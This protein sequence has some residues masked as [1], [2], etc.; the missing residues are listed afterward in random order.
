MMAPWNSGSIGASA[1]PPA[2]GAALNSRRR[3]GY[4]DSANLPRYSKEPNTLL[5]K[6]IVY[7]GDITKLDVDVIVNAANHSLLGGGGVD[8]AIHRKAGPQLRAFNQTLGGCK[9]SEVKASPGFNLFCKQI[10][11][12]VGP[13]G[14]QP[15]ALRSCYI[16]ALELLKVVVEC[17][18]KWLKVPSNFE[19]I[20]YI[21][22]CV[23]DKQDYTLYDQLLSKIKARAPVS[24]SSV[25]APPV[26]PGADGDGITTTSTGGEDAG[27]KP[28]L[29]TASQDPPH[30]GPTG[31]D[32]MIVDE[33][34]DEQ[35][36]DNTP[37]LQQQI[38]GAKESE[39]KK[40]ECLQK[41][42]RKDDSREGR[43][44]WGGSWV[45]CGGGEDATRE[46][47]DGKGD[48]NDR[49]RVFEY[50][51][52]KKEGMELMPLKAGDA[53]GEQEG[54]SGHH[55]SG[56]SS[57]S[58]TSESD[59]E[60][61]TEEEEQQ[62]GEED[63]E[64]D[65]KGW[66]VSGQ[67][68]EGHRPKPH[69][70]R[71]AG[72]LFSREYLHGGAAVGITGFISE[73]SGKKMR[74]NSARK[75]RASVDDIGGGNDS[76]DTLSEGYLSEQEQI[77]ERL[78][79]RK[80][81][82]SD[83]RCRTHAKRKDKRPKKVKISKKE[84]VESLMNEENA[85]EKFLEYSE[86]RG[87]SM[88][89]SNTLSSGATPRLT[90]RKRRELFRK[91]RVQTA[92]KE[93]ES[94]GQKEEEEDRNASVSTSS[95]PS[96]SQEFHDTMS[97][98]QVKAND[99]RSL[100]S[101][102]SLQSMKE[103]GKTHQNKKNDTESKKTNGGI[104]GSNNKAR[105]DATK[106]NTISTP[107]EGAGNN[108]SNKKSHQGQI[109]HNG[110]PRS[111]SSSTTPRGKTR[112]DKKQKTSKFQK[113][114][115]AR[116]AGSFE[117]CSSAT[118]GD[119]ATSSLLGEPSPRKKPSS[120]SS[121]FEDLKPSLRLPLEKVTK[122]KP[123]KASQSSSASSSQTVVRG[124][125]AGETTKKGNGD[126]QKKSKE[127]Q[128]ARG[129]RQGSGKNDASGAK[130]TKGH[131]Q[132][133]N[134][135]PSSDGTSEEIGDVMEKKQ[136]ST[137]RGGEKR[138]GT[139]AAEQTQLLENGKTS[140]KTVVSVATPRG[141]KCKGKNKDKKGTQQRGQDVEAATVGRIELP[142]VDPLQSD[143]LQPRMDEPPK[144]TAEPGESAKPK[145][146]SA[147]VAVSERLKNLQVKFSCLEKDQDSMSLSALTKSGNR[148][149]NDDTPRKGAS[150]SNRSGSSSSLS[151]F[152]SLPE[153]GEA[154]RG[155]EAP[156][157][158]K[159]GNSKPTKKGTKKPR[160]VQTPGK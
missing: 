46:E 142:P 74:K 30:H 8:G 50:R 139:P 52:D 15:Q 106:D 39:D 143:A 155:K 43:D 147:Q 85:F 80:D 72:E 58:R 158:R 112:H 88:S 19:A 6:V 130:T 119:S 76:S 105:S 7:K 113:L 94:E 152:H 134:A 98:T 91:Q 40:P 32:R 36:K 22:F 99:P 17:V 10:F 47:E 103:N 1:V 104:T 125:Q 41:K 135:I 133:R 14:E 138:E 56:S 5:R 83:R 44:D 110:G 96:T 25:F 82:L 108:E 115:A 154:S 73:R 124:E 157:P 37:S 3:S 90:P 114:A 140:S 29:G 151:S 117:K 31:R 150:G 53:S 61:A 69:I 148:A 79:D 64:Q 120:S 93:Q 63:Q 35:T 160:G 149:A 38:G 68:E 87:G 78:L 28:T 57:S 65:R 34:E 33:H 26:L 146:K 122:E 136:L 59:G 95:S 21:V 159:K 145:G 75:R 62:Q 70:P 141:G 156:S 4:V 126:G 107:K 16:N 118:L 49:T 55:K 116:G 111:L 128:S 20:D 153:S 12:T 123:Q 67:Q 131:T 102:E 97:G 100:P 101:G 77:M 89:G 2:G 137:V 129:L 86:R 84:N 127:S 144:K 11:H 60:S 23:F 51:G 27:E 132:A 45:L 9:T 42:F 66:G 109:E 71:L 81:D 92:R 18:S 13:R 121:S 48:E 54:E 24:I